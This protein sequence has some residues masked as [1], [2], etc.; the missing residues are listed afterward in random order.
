MANLFGVD[1]RS[2]WTWKDIRTQAHEIH[3]DNHHWSTELADVLHKTARRNSTGRDLIY[4]QHSESFRTIPYSVEA[5]AYGHTKFSLLL[6]REPSWD[7][8]NLKRA[9]PS[10]GHLMREVRNLIDSTPPN[11]T[12]YWL[13]CTPALGF[14]A[15]PRDE[16]RALNESMSNMLN[17]IQFICLAPDA[18]YSWHR[19]FLNAPTA[20]GNVTERHIKAATVVS[21]R[22]LATQQKPSFL[23]REMFPPFYMFSHSRRAILVAKFNFPNPQ[24]TTPEQPEMFGAV[25]ADPAVVAR[26]GRAQLGYM[27]PSGAKPEQSLTTAR[28][29]AVNS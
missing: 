18:L 25:T 1:E 6:L 20:R 10:F 8:D 13:A 4:R 9:V 15:R 29:G 27:N 5:P 2:P 12:L 23:T 26:I 22:L 21:N 14:L 24:E 16:W 7:R 17:R 28:P 11:D 3:S 19:E